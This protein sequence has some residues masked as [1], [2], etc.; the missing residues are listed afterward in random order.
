MATWNTHMEYPQVFDFPS[1]RAMTDLMVQ[2]TEWSE[3]KRA[4]RLV[5]PDGGDAMPGECELMEVING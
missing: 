1:I 2:L 5:Q 4:K 3:A